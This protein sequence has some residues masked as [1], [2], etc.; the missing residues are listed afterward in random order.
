MSKLL[1][2]VSFLAVLAGCNQAD[3]AS[4][5]LSQA[6][7]NFQIERRILFYNTQSVV[8]SPERIV[9]DLSVQ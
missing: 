5:N 3:V 7:D 6:A 9:P 2:Y 1:L 4:R 8:F